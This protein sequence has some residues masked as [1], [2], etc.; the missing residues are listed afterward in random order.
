MSKEIAVKILLIGIEDVSS[1]YEILWDLPDELSNNKQKIYNIFQFLLE[2]DLIHLY[3]CKEL[4]GEL[5]TISDPLDAKQLISQEKFWTPPTQDVTWLRYDT[6]EKGKVIY[7]QICEG[8]AD[9]FL[10]ELYT[11]ID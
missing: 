9:D 5:E 1:L 2:L 8:K 3:W 6:T 10:Q 7:N 11:S 4:Y